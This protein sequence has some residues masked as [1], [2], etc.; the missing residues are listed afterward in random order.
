MGYKVGT[1]VILS[2]FI[3]FLFQNCAG[4]KATDLAVSLS[5][6]GPGSS[7]SPFTITDPSGPTY[8]GPTNVSANSSAYLSLCRAVSG[9]TNLPLCPMPAITT[10]AEGGSYLDPVFGS[11][12]TLLKAG[13]QHHYSFQ[14]PF[15]KNSD[16]VI[17]HR[18]PDVRMA[19]FS[20]STGTQIWTPQITGE[21]W[22]AGEARWSGI[23]NDVF[24]YTLPTKILRLNV[25]NKTID[26]YIDLTLAPYNVDDADT[27]QNHD[28]A[29]DD[30]TA[31]F[32]LKSK[33]VCVVHLPRKLGRCLA[34]DPSPW[35]AQT[36]L[37]AGRI[38][39]D[40][41]KGFDSET[42]RLYVI[43]T[44]LPGFGVFSVDH[45]L[46]DFKFDF[47]AP[48]VI[49]EMKATNKPNDF[50]GI[51]ETGEEC[52]LGNIHMDTFQ[53]STGRQFLAPVEIGWSCKITFA[54]F[55]INKRQNLLVD[56]KAGGGRH[57]LDF[58][59]NQ[60][61]GTTPWS[62]A[63]HIGCAKNAP[64]CV[65]SVEYLDSATPNLAGKANFYSELFAVT[66]LGR[67]LKRLGQYR[68]VYYD[69]WDSPRPAISNDGKFVLYDSNMG[70]P[71][72][73]NTFLLE[74]KVA[75]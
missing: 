63:D 48:E 17:L 23:D 41:S 18:D 1:T 30:W 69:Y 21:S 4:F 62:Y 43:L 47:Q 59:I 3:V 52:A 32:S 28:L 5:S 61:G 64:T 16:Y 13:F 53:D 74:T 29:A 60:C 75:P 45:E 55:Q 14:S 20:V 26:T 73:K 67:D 44:A 51:C 7:T 71:G 70:T 12:I 56:A 19:V 72:A 34:Y 10:P 66:D 35:T 33:K 22:G 46:T 54:F 24:Y 58:N 27:G 31:F 38:D 37:E 42:K 25:K 50:D 6:S 68:S 40:I 39:L 11:K 57:K 15:S 36:P 2:I 8:K 49:Q 65:I 9:I